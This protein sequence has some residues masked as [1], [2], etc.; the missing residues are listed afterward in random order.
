[1]KKQ[2]TPS[3]RKHRGRW[4]LLAVLI[5]LI[6]AIAGVAV[7]QKNN[8][9]AVMNYTQY[10]QEELVGKLEENDAYIQQVLD[11]ALSNAQKVD[12]ERKPLK[13]PQKPELPDEPE[14][15]PTEAPADTPPEQAA[16]EDG[17]GGEEEP[18]FESQ[19]QALIDR[20]YALRDE[21]V[22][23]L[24]AMERDAAEA[25]RNLPAEKRTAKGKIEFASSYISRATELEKECDGKM[26]QL[27]AEF[28]ALLKGYGQS[29]ELVDTVIYTYANEKSLKKAWYLSELEKRGMI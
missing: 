18:S 2:R 22:G 28:K 17:G 24:E 29:M 15:T 11:E 5:V 9:E 4:I 6:G 19:L 20:V 10:T 1:M 3:G 8:I 21:Y 23:A 26:D 13:D 14:Q 25:Y 16:P 12:Q 7:W 27:V